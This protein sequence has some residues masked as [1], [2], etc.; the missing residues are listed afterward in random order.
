MKRILIEGFYAG[1]QARVQARS[2]TEGAQ[3]KF[4]EE[5]A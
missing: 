3:P 1:Q 4:T 5:R 2:I